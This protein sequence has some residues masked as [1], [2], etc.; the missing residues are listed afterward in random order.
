MFRV[1]PVPAAPDELEEP[2]EPE[3]EEEVVPVISTL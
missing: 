3:P 1:V 2:L